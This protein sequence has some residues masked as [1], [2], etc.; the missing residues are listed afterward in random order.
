MRSDCFHSESMCVFSQGPWLASG[1]PAIPKNVKYISI[2]FDCIR[3]LRSV[4]L[5]KGDD[6]LIWK[7]VMIF[8]VVLAV[9][10]EKNKNND[11]SNRI[12]WRLR[13]FSICQTQLLL[14]HCHSGL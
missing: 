5:K 14:L 11:N 4:R 1:A 8:E 13:S 3:P 6:E 12:I 10:Y 2:H 7:P 9:N